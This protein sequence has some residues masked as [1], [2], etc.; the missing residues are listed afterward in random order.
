MASLPLN[1]QRAHWR[2]NKIRGK[3][4]THKCICGKPARD[5]A[6]RHGEDMEDVNCYDAMCRS[7]HIKYDRPDWQK[8]CGAAISKAKVGIATVWGSDHGN[9]KLTEDRVA[10]MRQLHATGG[11][12]YRDMGKMFGVHEDTAK[13]AIRRKTWRHV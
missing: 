6:L 13:N 9:A 8:A 11:Y 7:C 2:V 4:S 5:W 3:A 12:S 1:Y 10:Q